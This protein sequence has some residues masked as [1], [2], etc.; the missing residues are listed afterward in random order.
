[1]KERVSELALCGD[2]DWVR[3]SLD[4]QV[5]P[6]L[7]CN[8]CPDN[9]LSHLPWSERKDVIRHESCPPRSMVLVQGK[10]DL[11]LPS[12]RMALISGSC[13]R[14]SAIPSLITNIFHSRFV[15]SNTSLDGYFTVKST[16]RRGSRAVCLIFP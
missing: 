12:M 4:Y 11:R 13:G 2:I 9:R 14:T 15:L 16:T 1:M 5:A 8:S 3:K 6:S 10:L 7:Y